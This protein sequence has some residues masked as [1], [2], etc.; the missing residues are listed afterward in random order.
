MLS[1]SKQNAVPDD[2]KYQSPHHCG[3]PKKSQPWLHGQLEDIESSLN[4]RYCALGKARRVLTMSL[5]ASAQL[6]HPSVALL[7]YPALSGHIL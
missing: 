6:M 5:P 2:Q 1:G 3:V 4:K 7:L